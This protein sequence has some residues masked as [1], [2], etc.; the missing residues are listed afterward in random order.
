ML[1]IR[2]NKNQLN[3]LPQ[4]IW[5]NTDIEN[6]ILISEPNLSVK[7]IAQN[8]VQ[9]EDVIGVVVS[10]ENGYNLSGEELRE[11]QTYGL[12][13][14]ETN[15]IPDYFDQRVVRGAWGNITD[16]KKLLKLMVREDI[17]NELGDYDIYDQ[18]ADTD[19]LIGQLNSMLMHMLPQMFEHIKK[20]DAT[21]NALKTLI[22]GAENIENLDIETEVDE[23]VSIRDNNYVDRYKQL[24]QMYKAGLVTDRSWLLEEGATQEVA[25]IQRKTQIANIVKERY[26]EPLKTI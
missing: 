10:K 25:M 18:L 3:K 19:K 14:V 21:I 24:L 4:P 13:Y 23:R 12:D 22:D 8:R 2:T 5:D 11:I 6:P 15:V 20:Q 1:I 9:L 17:E 16:I 7:I 26:I